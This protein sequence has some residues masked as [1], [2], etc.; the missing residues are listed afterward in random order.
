LARAV[1]A[2][3]LTRDLAAGAEELLARLGGAGRR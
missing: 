1:P 3:Q 2:G